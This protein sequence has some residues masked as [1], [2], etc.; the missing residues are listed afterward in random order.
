MA[1]PVLYHLG[2]FPPSN[3]DWSRLIPLI[4]PAAAAIARYDGALSAVPNARVLLSPL[5]TQEAVLS[6]RIEG[7]QATMGEVL[8]FEA[9]AGPAER[10]DDTK[11]A[12]IHEIINYRKAIAGAA[13]QL[14]EVPLS[15]RLIRN[16]HR[17]LMSGVRGQNRD[18]GEYRRVPNWIGP[19]N[20]SLEGARFVPIPVQHVNE[21]MS[22][23]EKYLHSEQPDH[24]VQLAICHAEFEALHPF[25]DGNGRL[26][27]M[28][29]PLYL[30]ERKLLASPNFYIS[31][32]LEARRDEYYERLLAVSRD[33]DWTGWC[34]FF[35]SA[36]QVQGVANTNKAQA[37]LNLY[38]D[39][40]AWI[41]EN[42]RSQYAI[43]ALDFIFDRPVFRSSD[44]VTHAG[45]PEPTAKRLLRLMQ[46]SGLLTVLREGAGRRPASLAFRELI[47]LTEGRPVL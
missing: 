12:E 7:T 3:L 6:S 34:E 40:K 42:I 20:C 14:A 18:P 25:L 2:S 47:N 35:L 23:W 33:G 44:F 5:T 36:L 10:G 37:I 31:E 19:L 24:L 39:K 11:T 15:Q 41:T 46:T 30:Y 1:G 16:A 43:R 28:L 29:I 17:T 45:I 32:Y 21:G 9:G 13:E 4:G 27:R 8:E 22:A 26:G 38:R